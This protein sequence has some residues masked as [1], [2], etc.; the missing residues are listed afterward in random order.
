MSTTNGKPDFDNPSEQGRT[1]TASVREDAAALK[2]DVTAEA[3]DT[4]EDLR[5]KTDDVLGTVQEKGAEVADAVRTKADDLANQGKQAGA[6]KAQG[7]AGAVRRVA[8]D[9]ETTSP[10]IAKHVRTAADSIEGIAGSLR[11]RSVGSLIEE[12]SGFARRQPA[13]FIGAAVLAGFAVSRFAKSSAASAAATASSPT[14][15]SGLTGHAPGWAPT[16]NGQEARPLTMSAATLGGVAAHRPGAAGPGSMPT[17]DE[18][19]H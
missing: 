17:I 1:G 12:V 7:F 8:D 11:E 4:G 13:A 18:G 10:E 16:T 9:L 15:P 6:D 19:T 3:R 5:A 2:R 14:T